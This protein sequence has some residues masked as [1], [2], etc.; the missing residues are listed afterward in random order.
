MHR[1]CPITCGTGRL[2]NKACDALSGQG[3]CSYPA[4]SQCPR[5]LS[6]DHFSRISCNNLI[7][8]FF[9]SPKKLIL[10]ANCIKGPIKCGNHYAP[11]CSQCPKG[12]GAVWCNG[13]CEW[14]KSSCVP[15]SK[16]S[17]TL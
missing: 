12:N 2:T 9:C 6:S 14:K 15:K 10:S 13:D 11:N 4:E 8:I 17:K 7:K 16:Y 1:C 5:K 3:T